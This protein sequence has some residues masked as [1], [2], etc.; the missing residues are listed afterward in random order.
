MTVIGR[1]LLHLWPADTSKH[2]FA[3][4]LYIKVKS[5]LCYCSHV[6][7]GILLRSYPARLDER[8]VRSKQHGKSGRVA[9]ILFN[10]LVIELIR[11]SIDPGK[12]LRSR[13]RLT[14]HIKLCRIV[15]TDFPATIGV[16]S[17]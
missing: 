4:L 13:N 17:V 9:C 11:R 6:L 15:I 16:L 14:D 7:R 2:P 8:T 10:N 12:V 3:V 5:F 1:A